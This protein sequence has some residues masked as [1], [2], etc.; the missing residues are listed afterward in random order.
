MRGIFLPWLSVLRAKV[1]ISH[2]K[3]G[4]SAS[5]LLAAHFMFIAGALK[6]YTAHPTL[7]AF[8]GTTIG[9]IKGFYQGHARTIVR[10][11]NICPKKSVYLILLQSQRC[12][13]Y[14]ANL[15]LSKNCV[16]VM[17]LESYGT[18]IF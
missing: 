12:A 4:W 10:W 8:P 17:N 3:D 16:L 6:V 11:S 15:G 18:N 1:Q 13:K 9:L 7:T 2:P 5:L 14:S